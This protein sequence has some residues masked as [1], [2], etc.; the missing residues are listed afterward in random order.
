MNINIDSL[1]LNKWHKI[2]YEE[3]GFKTVSW[4]Q[5]GQPTKLKFLKSVHVCSPPFIIYEVAKGLYLD[6]EHDYLDNTT[7]V[8]KRDFL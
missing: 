8:R 5:S 1:P 4:S 2:S 3:I 6:W 7:N